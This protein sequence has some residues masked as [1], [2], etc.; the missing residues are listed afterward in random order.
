MSPALQEGR[1]LLQVAGGAWL[2][3]KTCVL[4]VTLSWARAALPRATL[5]ER[6]RWTALR[7]APLSVLAVVATVAWSWWSPVR[8]A[9]L[10]VSGV[11][12]AAV[13]LA[14]VALAHRIRHALGGAHADGRLSPFL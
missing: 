9:Q 2:L 10:L 12:V 3:A 14:G 6:T 8:P 1:P 7:L 11:L 4:V 13:G 5:A